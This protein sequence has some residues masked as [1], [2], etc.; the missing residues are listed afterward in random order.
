MIKLVND[1]LNA[2]RIEEGRFG[3]EFQNINF[4]A[5]LE[6]ITKN[7]SDMARQKSMEVRFEN[8]KGKT[9]VIYG[10]QER[11]ALAVNNLLENAIKYTKA[12]GKVAVT[13]EQKG[14]YA[15]I[16]ISDTGVGIPVSEQKRVFSKFFRASNVIRMETEGT[17]LGLFIVRN[18]IKRHGGDIYF[19]S[20]EGD[21][22]NFTF[23]IP[24]K[25]EL[26]P[27]EEAPTLEEFLET[28]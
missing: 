17:G 21:G 1:L 20:K 24:I 22:S 26:V 28:I 4:D 10:D 18:I 8:K 5:F 6:N 3:Y 16:S 15:L 11:L 2:A 7:Y 13:L 19:T 23:T 14:D 9:V 12:G 27:R 25:K